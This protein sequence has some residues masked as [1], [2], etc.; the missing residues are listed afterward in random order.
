MVV[1]LGASPCNTPFSIVSSSAGRA[2]QDEKWDKL[3][4]KFE[5]E[6]FSE[7]RTTED[8]RLYC[9]QRRQQKTADE[10]GSSSV[11]STSIAE[12]EMM[13]RPATGHIVLPHLGLSK[14]I[15][16]VEYETGLHGGLEGS[17]LPVMTA[18]YMQAN[19]P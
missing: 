12:P 13:E 5:K 7:D 10:H 14:H 4:T 8:N 1:R 3:C 9:E 18:G 6:G 19:T 16:P 15:T 17:E 11:G 2:S